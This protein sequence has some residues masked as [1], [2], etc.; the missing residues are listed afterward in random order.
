MPA[1]NNF[2]RDVLTGNGFVGALLGLSLMLTLPSEAPA[3]DLSGVW[4]A[5]SPRSAGGA[6]RPAL[7]ARAQADADAFDPLN[8]PVIRCVSGGFPRTGLIIYPF[9]IVQTEKMVVFLYEA[10]GMVRRVYM[11]GRNLPAYLPAAV[12]G[13]SEGR[14]DGETLVVETGNIAS[15]LLSGGGVP[16]YGDVEVLERYTISDDGQ[17]LEGEVTL[18]APGTFVASWTRNFTWQLDPEGMIFESLCDPNDSRF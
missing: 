5:T 2:G 10:F 17:V 12:S 3:A 18:T 9:E 6:N 8:D 7:T 16:Q 13:Y 1:G 11:D 4:L 14:W 15:G